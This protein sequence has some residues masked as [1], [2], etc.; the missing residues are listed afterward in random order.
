MIAIGQSGSAA[1]ARDVDALLGRLDQRPGV[2]MGCNVA[3]EGLFRKESTA[4]AVAALRFCLDGPVL[5]VTA[6]SASG[7]A[8]LAAVKSLAAFH[9]GAGSLETRMPSGAEVVELLRRFLAMFRPQSAEFAYYGALSFDYF[10]LGETGPLPDDGRRRLVLFVPERVLAVRESGARWLDF[11]FSRGRPGPSARCR[12]CP[13]VMIATNCQRA[14]M[15]LAL[16]AASNGCG[17]ASCSLWC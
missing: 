9:G 11:S 10:R 14:V 15:R 2:W 13:L 8:L 3:S 4:C 16:P 12:P 1:S 5:T 17:A 7:G 6:L